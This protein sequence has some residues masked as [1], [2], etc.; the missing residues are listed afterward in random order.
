ML[1]TLL[2]RFDAAY[3]AELE[4]ERGAIEARDYAKLKIAAERGTVDEVLS[5][6]R[7]PRGAVMRIERVWMVRLAESPGLGE[8]VEEAIEV[9]RRR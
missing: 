9:E 4:K 1:K 2:D 3:V 5:E 6:L 8:K 7:L